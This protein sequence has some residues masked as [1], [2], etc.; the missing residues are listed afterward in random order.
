MREFL[1]NTTIIVFHFSLLCLNFSLLVSISHFSCA[2]ARISHFW[3]EF[4]TCT[5]RTCK[6]LT[7]MFEFL[8]FGNFCS[9]I[10]TFPAGHTLMPAGP[11]PRRLALYHTMSLMGWRMPAGHRSTCRRAKSEKF[12]HKSEKFACSCRKSEKFKPKVRNWNIKVRNSHLRAGKVRN[13][14]I[15]A[16]KV[17]NSN[18]KWELKYFYMCIGEKFAR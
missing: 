13:L 17:R 3:F 4:L 16:G 15:C 9:E 14:R 18:H 1:T 11:L 7:C 10:L 8:T 5:A 12:K 6:F 2:D